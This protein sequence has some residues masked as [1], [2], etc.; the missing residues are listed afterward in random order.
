MNRTSP[1]EIPAPV[2]GRTPEPTNRRLRTTECPKPVREPQ[3]GDTLVRVVSDYIRY[4]RARARAE[5]M[6]FAR[7]ISLREAVRLAG[8]AQFEDGRRFSHQRRIPADVLRRATT[9]LLAALP[10]IAAC[11]G[12]DAL[13]DLV[14]SVAGS[15]PGIGALTVY[16]TANR[17]G[18]KLGLE[19]TRIFLHA[20]TGE[21]ARVLGLP[22]WG[23]IEMPE[24]LRKFPAFRPLR[25]REVEDALC[26]FKRRLKYI[27]ASRARQ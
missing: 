14:R 9:G 20:G 26:I 6:H 22:A 23:T 11:P 1:G 19:P 17:I 13:H 2:A 15:I 10:R 24:L 4:C 8:L 18:A 27:A 16:D 7:L 5:R 25:P 12:F 21:G 3:R